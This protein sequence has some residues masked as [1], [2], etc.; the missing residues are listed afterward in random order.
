MSKG[1]EALHLG[2]VLLSSSKDMSARPVDEPDSPSP[3]DKTK[4]YFIV[5]R[6]A[7]LS[8]CPLFMRFHHPQQDPR[9]LT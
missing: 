8:D 9:Y 6:A 1:E 3:K 2:L 5:E 4:L 7:F